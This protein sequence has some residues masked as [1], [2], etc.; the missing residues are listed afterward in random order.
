MRK[1]TSMKR[2]NPFFSKGVLQTHNS[3]EAK[4][5]VICNITNVLT[6]SICIVMG[7]TLSIISF[8][9]LNLVF[10]I[11][12]ICYLITHRILAAGYTSAAKAMLFYVILAH[13]LCMSI[14]LGKHADV[15]NFYIPI[16][17]LPFLFFGQKEKELFYLSVILSIVNIILV[18]ST[19]QS[20]TSPIHYSDETYQ[21]I[22]SVINLISISCMITLSFL[23]L[24]LTE[25]GEKELLK[26]NAELKL[27]KEEQE[28]MNVLK[29]HLF[30]IISHDLRSPI[31]VIHGLTDLIIN[32]Q[33]TKEEENMLAERLKQSADNTNQLL[34]NL[35]NW[36]E[37][38]IK[39]STQLSKS[40]A[41]KIK[42]LIA[43][44]FE[45]LESKATEKNIKLI[46]NIDDAICIQCDKG[47]LEIVIRNLITNAIKFSY[48]DQRVIVGAE[49]KNEKTEIRVEDN[50]I[51]IPKELMDKLFT[52]DK[53]I[54]REGTFKEKGSGI[55]L[56]LCKHLIESNGGKISATSTPRKQTIFTLEL[57]EPVAEVVS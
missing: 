15:K 56:L 5:I 41:V 34:D 53:T 13:T 18:Y 42:N 7:T 26:L 36:S 3:I 54:S 38:Q 21:S 8:Y 33:L 45:Q 22:N 49:K 24:Q 40:E 2:I 19:Q 25:S 16:A 17:I 35:L 50:G 9:P 52:K 39:N 11:A 31:N 6:I 30:G 12:G 47:M 32:N 1:N 57:S 4:R 14:I 29:D 46:N 51:G 27:A 44:V 48:S 37:L 28:R 20:Y 55:G 43:D 10:I 23:F